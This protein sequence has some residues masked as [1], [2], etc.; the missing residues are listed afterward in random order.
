VDFVDQGTTTPVRH[1]NASG[2]PS[3]AA[4]TASDVDSTIC[5]S[6]SSGCDT[7]PDLGTPSAGT[8]DAATTN[9]EAADN[10]TTQLASTS[11]VQQEINGAGGTDLSCSSGQCNVDAA[12]A[13]L[14]D[15]DFTSTPTAPTAAGD[16]NTTQLATTA[17]VQQEINDAGGTDLT[18]ATGTCDVDAAVARLAGPAL[19]GDPTAP[20]AS[21]DDDDTSIATTAYVQ[22]EIAEFA[23]VAVTGFQVIIPSPDIANEYV[24]LMPPFT[25]TMTRVDCESFGGT[26]V[27]INI[28][29]G[30]DIGDDTCTTSILDATASTTLECTTSPT[31]DTSLNATGFAARDKVSLVLTADSGTVDQLTVML[32]V[33]VD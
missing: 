15:P 5:Q 29:D 25:G 30:E 28:C 13:R 26:S 17:F 19:T 6:D 23:G 33:T 10:N 27:T 16:T 1:G 8:L 4:V 9:L 32:T 3:F 20:T 11:F 22:A 24:I 14:A 21:A 2:N 12:V 7:T 31:S 18:C